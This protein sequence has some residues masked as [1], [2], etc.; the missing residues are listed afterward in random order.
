M[1][2]S[3]AEETDMQRLNRLKDMIFTDK[4]HEISKKDLRWLAVMTGFA[5]H[6]NDTE[7]MDESEIKY[8]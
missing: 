3:K 7:R 6:Q 1:L 5:I 4:N 2:E 8:K